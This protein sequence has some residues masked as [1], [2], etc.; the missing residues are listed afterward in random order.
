MKYGVFEGEPA[1][2]TLYE[3]WVCWRGE[4]KS[5]PPMEVMGNAH[6]VSEAEYYALFPDAPPDPTGSPKRP[7]EP[8][9]T[10]PS[11]DALF[12][13]LPGHVRIAQRRAVTTGIVGHRK[14]V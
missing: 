9:A 3:A 4:W 5:F 13:K 2:W 14:L 7:E 10:T 11:M 8:A 12:E 6:V 1:R